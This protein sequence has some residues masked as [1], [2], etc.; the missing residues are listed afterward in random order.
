MLTDFT[1]GYIMP[2]SCSRIL[3]RIRRS[4][5]DSVVSAVGYVGFCGV[6]GKEVS[7]VL[8]RGKRY[9]ANLQRHFQSAAHVQN[10]LAYGAA[11]EGTEDAADLDTAAGWPL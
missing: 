7:L 5:V 10:S 9:L 8:S 11:L 4:S 1:S 6:C 3:R 2:Y